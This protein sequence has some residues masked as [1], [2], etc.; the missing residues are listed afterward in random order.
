M[1]KNAVLSREFEANPDGK[2]PRYPPQN[3]ETKIL[4]NMENWGDNFTGI[5]R[6]QK[7]EDR[8]EL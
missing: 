1:C 7:E 5:S 4:K 2:I 3:P 6:R 8:E